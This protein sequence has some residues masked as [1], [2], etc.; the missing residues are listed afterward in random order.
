VAAYALYVFY[1]AWRCQDL[2]IS[3]GAAR[4]L[5]FGLPIC[6]SL[7]NLVAGKGP[8]VS[9]LP[10]VLVGLIFGVVSGSLALLGMW[11]GSSLGARSR[12]QAAWLSGTLLV[13][14]S[15]CLFLREALY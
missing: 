11:L 2:T 15:G 6:L 10:A 13:I 8:E 9:G 14:V 5:V 1:L 3:P 12:L 4:W 7:D